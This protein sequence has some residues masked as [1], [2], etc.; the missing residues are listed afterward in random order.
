MTN[1]LK[2]LRT[3]DKANRVT[4]FQMYE[5]LREGRKDQ[6]GTWIEGCFL[7]QEQ[8]L[9][10]VALV[11]CVLESHLTLRVINYLR[12]IEYKPVEYTAFVCLRIWKMNEQM[13]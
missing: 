10:L 13:G 12:S 4:P 3:L 1:Y 2:V 5:M 6:S 9:N 11:Y 7:N 8:A